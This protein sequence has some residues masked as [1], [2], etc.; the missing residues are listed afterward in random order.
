MEIVP[1]CLASPDYV[2]REWLCLQAICWKNL[3]YYSVRNAIFA[4]MLDCM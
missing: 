4:C 2:D 1:F 3:L